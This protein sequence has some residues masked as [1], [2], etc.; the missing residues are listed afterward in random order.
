[1]H[2]FLKT[3]A[4]AGLFSAALIQPAFAEVGNVVPEPSSLALV[5]VAVGA[6]VWA[7]RRKK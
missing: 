6:A 5:G 3:L 7:L 4:A 2:A 1:M